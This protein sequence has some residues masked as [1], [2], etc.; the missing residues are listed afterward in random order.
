MHTEPS[1]A[2]PKDA[3]KGDVKSRKKCETDGIE[4]RYAEC[5]KA[6]WSAWP[7]ECMKP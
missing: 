2:K 1:E 6:A 5:R 4:V 3:A 7:P